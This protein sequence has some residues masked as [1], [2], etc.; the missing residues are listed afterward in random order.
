MAGT[1]LMTC[2][3]RIRQAD[4]LAPMSGENKSDQYVKTARTLYQQAGGAYGSRD[5]Q[6]A[7]FLAQASQSIVFALESIAQAA[8]P[9]PKKPPLFK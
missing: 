9:I 1:A 8:I 3:S 7:M 5:Y 2:F 6:K 4:F